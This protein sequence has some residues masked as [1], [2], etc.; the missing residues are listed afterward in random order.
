MLPRPKGPRQF[1]LKNTCFYSQLLYIHAVISFYFLISRGSKT[2]VHRYLM[3]INKEYIRFAVKPRGTLNENVLD[4]LK[5]AR[6]KM[7]V[8]KSRRAPVLLHPRTQKSRK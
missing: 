2:R 6:S 8:L 5:Q 3:I 1:C 4:S 7:E